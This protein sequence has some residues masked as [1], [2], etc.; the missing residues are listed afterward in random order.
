MPT[1][2]P[3]VKGIFSLPAASIVARRRAG[4]LVGEPAWT[5]SIRRSEVDSS[6]KPCEAVTSRRR[7]RSSELSTPTLVW[8]RMPRSSAR[9]QAQTT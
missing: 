6:I 3:L 5:V 7:A 9:S 1:R 8:G 2:M 4:C